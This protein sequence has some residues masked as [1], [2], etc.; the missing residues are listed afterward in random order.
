MLL[1]VADLVSVKLRVRRLK[2]ALA[3]EV[4]GIPRFFGSYDTPRVKR[5][6]HQKRSP[7]QQCYTQRGRLAH[8][9]Q[10]RGFQ[11]CSGGASLGVFDFTEARLK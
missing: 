4:A 3:M 5:L 1:E 8:R 6:D 11:G 9:R 7:Q 10:R 2:A